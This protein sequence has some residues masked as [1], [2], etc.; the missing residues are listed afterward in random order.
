MKKSELKYK[1]WMIT[2]ATDKNNTID[3]P[4]REEVERVLSEEGEKWLFQ[5]EVHE[6]SEVEK[7]HYQCCLVTKIRKR[8]N[9]VLKDLADGL[10]HPIEYISIQKMNGTWE[11]AMLYCSKKDGRV[12]EV[13]K[14]ASISLDY[15]FSDIKFLDEENRRYLYGRTNY[16]I[17]FLRRLRGGIRLTRVMIV[18]LSGL[19]TKWEIVENLSYVSGFVLVMILLLRFHSEQATNSERE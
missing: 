2:I 4:P 5:E 14:S 7:T 1:S 19:P 16:W 6:N 11:Q 15:D 13:V 18:R 8:K 3:L 12:G 10:G 17:N 9:T